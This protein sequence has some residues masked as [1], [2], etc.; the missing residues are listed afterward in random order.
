MKRCVIEDIVKKLEKR[1]GKMSLTIDKMHTYVGMNLIYNDDGSLSIEMKDY[2]MEAI[3]EYPEELRKHAKTP[4]SSN[5]F[6]VSKDSKLLKEKDRVIL[7]RITARLL[8]VSKHARSDIQVAV[9]FLSTRV[10]KATAEDWA[11]LTRL[12]RYIKGT[13]DMV[14]TMKIEDLS[15]VKW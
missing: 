2:L 8:F 12:M 15:V 1:Y 9:G 14:L 6:A 10:T 5:L 13:I 7:H 4:A 3:E 11:K